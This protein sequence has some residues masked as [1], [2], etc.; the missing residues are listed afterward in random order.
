MPR[1]EPPGRAEGADFIE[2]RLTGEQPEPRTIVAVTISDPPE[3]PP[4]LPGVTRT[5][6]G[7]TLNL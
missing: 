1:R 4:V 2:N 6:V 5:S 3:T 7:H